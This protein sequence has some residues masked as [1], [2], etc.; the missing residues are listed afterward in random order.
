MMQFYKQ[1]KKVILKKKENLRN[2]NKRHKNNPIFQHKAF[3]K[4]NIDDKI[5]NKH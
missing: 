2:G 1:K 4:D 5:G 3:I